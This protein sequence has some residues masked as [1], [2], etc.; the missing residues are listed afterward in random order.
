MSGKITRKVSTMEKLKE[1]FASRK[2]TWL[3]LGI[4]AFVIFNYY[5]EKIPQVYIVW[6]LMD[7]F[8]Y[9]ADAAYLSGDAWPYITDFYYGFG[10]SLLLVPLF[11]IFDTGIEIIRGAIVIN[12][13]NVVA[14]FLVQYI[15]MSK[16][17]KELNRNLI[18]VCSFALSF[19]PYIVA[20]G[21]KVVCEVTLTLVVWLC[22][23]LLYQ[24]L[25][26]GKWYYYVLLVVC[27][28]YM[29]FVHSRTFV[30]AGVMVMTIGVMLLFKQ[31]HWKQLFM[32]AVTAIVVLIIGFSVKSQVIDNVYTETIAEKAEK[33]VAASVEKYTGACRTT[34]ALESTEES[35]ERVE[36]VSEVES[37]ETLTE[38]ILEEKPKE[39]IED[40]KT[41]TVKNVFTLSYVIK[42]IMNVFSNFSV[43]YIYGFA[44]R[45][46]YLFVGTLGMFHIG[47][48]VA[49][50]DTFTE[51]KAQK[52]IGATNAVKFL[53]AMAAIMA[54][55]AIVVHSPYSFEL[56]AYNFY[57]RYYEYAVGPMIFLGLDYCL[58]KKISF[59]GK[60]VW[61][62]L[63][64]ASYWFTMDFANYLEVQDLNF[65]SF[66]LAAISYFTEAQ[67]YR[68]VWMTLWM[69]RRMRRWSRRR[70]SS[71][72]PRAT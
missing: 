3:L 20:S 45:N 21:L 24:A 44:C 55:L 46:F 49:L 28:A 64:L 25:D 30:F 37:T 72:R 40:N 34:S 41:S 18:V 36:A 48:F 16:I 63:F 67:Y 6:E 7:E 70:R 65:D 12:A 13:I 10:Y 32:M 43:W 71:S 19:Y 1:I 27:T 14:L 69:P 22:G 17:C 50:K 57:G 39:N 42:R 29:F 60:V 61:L 53:L 26:K 56:P 33:I 11:W 59:S 51:W 8:G 38:E 52:K 9:L 47:V 35:L 5:F 54:V 58:R 31:I 23:L 66:R 2:F 68:A 4:G 62:V 15:L